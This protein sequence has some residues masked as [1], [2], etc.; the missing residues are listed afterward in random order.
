MTDH[1]KSK[2]TEFLKEFVLSGYQIGSGVLELLM[3]K[4]NPESL[5]KTIIRESGKSN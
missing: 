2:A 5:I 1:I 4:E 3:S